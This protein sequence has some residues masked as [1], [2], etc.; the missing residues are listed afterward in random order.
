MNFIKFYKI[1]FIKLCCV[2]ILKYAKNNK[3]FMK[4]VFTKKVKDSRKV[5]ARIIISILF[6]LI[7][8]ILG[9]LIFK[10]FIEPFQNLSFIQAVYFTTS[11]AL[12]IGYGDITPL[13]DAGR[14]FVIVYSFLMVS[15]GAYLLFNTGR[16]VFVNFT[17]SLRSKGMEVKVFKKTG[18]GGKNLK[19]K[20]IKKKR[21]KKEKRK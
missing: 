17:G 16:Y 7:L 12:T 5:K 11:T 3:E 9:A 4:N 6:Y 14:L 19:K 8:V 18:K 13:S 15:M 10:Y 2:F 21:T 1:K 20:I